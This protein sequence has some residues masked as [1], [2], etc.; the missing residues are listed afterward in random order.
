MKL[1]G[2]TGGIGMGKSTTASFLA[3]RGIPVID[4]DPAG[5]K[6]A[7]PRDENYPVMLEATGGKVFV[8]ATGLNHFFDNSFHIALD[9]A[10]YHDIILYGR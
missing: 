1:F 5:P 9:Q 4:T 2:L 3:R 8:R 6:P 10:R 7:I